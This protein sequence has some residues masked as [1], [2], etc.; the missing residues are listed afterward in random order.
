MLLWCKVLSGWSFK[1]NIN[2]NCYIKKKR[3][4]RTCLVFNPA[5]KMRKR[6]YA[7][8]QQLAFHTMTPDLMPEL[9]PQNWDKR[10]VGQRFKEWTSGWPQTPHPFPLN[11]LTSGLKYFLVVLSFVFDE[12]EK[13]A[14]RRTSN[15]VAK[16]KHILSLRTE[17]WK[18]TFST[19]YIISL[20][21]RK[22]VLLVLRFQILYIKWIKW[23]FLCF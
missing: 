9:S 1:R 3:P 17:N 2:F 14:I 12:S 18:F 22:L 20:Q 16:Q 13:Q 7:A 6:K 15:G 11:I 4:P 21:K 10:E 5:Q 19:V 23:D 8:M